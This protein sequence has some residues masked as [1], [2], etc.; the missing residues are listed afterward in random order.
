MIFSKEPGSSLDP[1]SDPGSH[2]TTK[3]GFDLTKPLQTA[4]KEFNKAEF[5]DI[6]LTQFING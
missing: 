4:G 1:S 2:L 3:V 5:P 6:D